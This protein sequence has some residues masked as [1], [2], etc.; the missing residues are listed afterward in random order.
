M[1]MIK[2]LEDLIYR[3]K[4][5]INDSNLIH[6]G[7]IHDFVYSDKIPL[8]SFTI[9]TEDFTSDFII[10]HGTIARDG[11]Y[12][13]FK[14][15]EIITLYK[16]FKNLKDLY[17]RYDYLPM[18]ITEEVGAHYA[19]EL[20]FGYNFKPNEE[21]HE[22]EVDLVIID[23]SKFKEIVEKDYHVSPGYHD[24]IKGNIQF[25]LDLDHI[26]LSLH[27]EGKEMAR[28]CTGQNDYGKSCTTVKKVY[29]QNLRGV[30]ND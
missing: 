1:I 11:P 13:Y 28:A 2:S 22:I 12:D 4:D 10:L 26:A 27:P 16:D 3:Y 19:E 6:V 8:K 7:N 15:G 30:L 18:K 14:N 17:S 29:D 20:G 25:I 21:T 5:K 23:P 24:Y 9:I